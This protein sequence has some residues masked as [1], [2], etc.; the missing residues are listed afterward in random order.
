MDFNT[1]RA[2]VDEYFKTTEWKMGEAQGW[3]VNRAKEAEVFTANQMYIRKF[4][5]QAAK[6]LDKV[7]SADWGG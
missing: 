2:R 1:M 5:N 3:G 6:L 4:P 7:T